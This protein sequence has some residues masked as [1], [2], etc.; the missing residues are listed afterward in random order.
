[1]RIL[2]ICT[3]NAAPLI[4]EEEKLIPKLAN[5]KTS[6]PSSEEEL[7]EM[8][9]NNVTIIS[10]RP[11]S[12]EPKIVIE[13]KFNRELGLY[14]PEYYNLI[15][16]SQYAFGEDNSAINPL[17]IYAF[18]RL[19]PDGG[20][21]FCTAGEASE[22][23]RSV[24]GA[25]QSGDPELSG[26]GGFQFISP[27]AIIALSESESQR[28]LTHDILNL[29]A[30][31]VPPSFSN[32][33]LDTFPPNVLLLAPEEM[34]FHDSYP[35]LPP[36][37]Y[38]LRWMCED[39]V[40]RA[41]K[42]INYAP[43]KVIRDLKAVTGW[44]R[45]HRKGSRLVVSTVSRVLDSLGLLDEESAIGSCDTFPG[46]GWHANSCYMDSA[47]QCLLAVPSIIGNYIMNVN[48]E[49]FPLNERE[50]M[51]GDTAAQDL[52][53]RERIQT[54]L[55]YIAATIRGKSTSS[56][57]VNN[58]NRFRLLLRTCKLNRYQRFW[59]GGT[60]DSGEF[61]AWLLAR[62]P[63][64]EGIVRR[65]TY[66]VKGK[67]MLLSSRTYTREG[68][69][70]DVTR[71]TLLKASKD[72]GDVKI[73]KFLTTS[74]DSGLIDG[75]FL[76]TE[77]RGKGDRFFRRIQKSMVLS[78]PGALIFTVMR[79]GTGYG[80]NGEPFI[81][82]KLKTRINPVRRFAL[83]S[84]QIFRFSAVTIHQGIHYYCYYRC[85]EDWYYYDDMSQQ[86]PKKIG[87]FTKLMRGGRASAIMSYGTVYYYNQI[88]GPSI[89][90]MNL[91]QK[92]ALETRSKPTESRRFL[93]C[94]GL[95]ITECT[96]RDRCDWNKTKK[97]CQAVDMEGQFIYGYGEEDA[98]SGEEEEEVSGDDY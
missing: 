10:K 11:L 56:T 50:T 4:T 27:D 6:R 54:E 43:P 80:I 8:I 51:C 17:D 81:H 67:E 65:E 57:R 2:F 38:L 30:G 14:E 87:T 72:K 75:G 42:V 13:E 73:T 74:D 47:L 78:S 59:E 34:G 88:G 33:R 68:P 18:S 53:N 98:G 48:L 12:G 20:L 95:E 26:D 52:F 63:M 60:Q 71:S 37:P 93:P 21:A 44:C 19:A 86:T 7:D 96:K 45:R 49:D 58:A 61:L 89:L 90:P 79:G 97:E 76:V 3:K 91:P 46:L 83:Q 23:V 36:W 66:A 28:T 69:V 9:R 70:V 31:A 40:H 5:L 92:P 77:Y 29:L 15:L 32:N 62:F 85:N 24:V 35:G 16:V 64:D 82:R 55:R 84:G 1:M 22:L 41:R 94:E 25:P 39:I